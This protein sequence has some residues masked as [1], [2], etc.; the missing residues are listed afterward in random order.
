VLS[1]GGFFLVLRYPPLATAYEEAAL[2][3]SAVVI[4][5]RKREIRRSH[6]IIDRINHRAVD[7]ER[8]K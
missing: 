3:H 2:R 8:E 1:G 6:R 5:D 7:R 4:R